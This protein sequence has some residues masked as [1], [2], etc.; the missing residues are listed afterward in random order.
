MTESTPQYEK[1]RLYSIIVIDFKRD[2]EQPRKYFDPEAL[3][4][5]AESIRKHGILQPVL[6]RPD[7]QGWV[8][9]VAGER[10]IEAAKMAGLLMIPAI[11]VEGNPDEI[12]LVENLQRR[13]LNPIEE[14][15]ALD[16]IMKKHNY[17]QDGLISVV[18][19]SKARISELLSLNR[20]PEEIK[21]ECRQNPNITRNILIEIA[22]SKQERGM[23]T[24]YK[25]YKEKQLTKEQLKGQ[26]RTQRKTQAQALLTNLGNVRSRM[27]A[28]DWQTWTDTERQELMTA[29]S[30]LKQIFDN[31]AVNIQTLPP[32]EETPPVT[33]DESPVSVDAAPAPVEQT[34]P[35]EEGPTPE[36]EIPPLDEG[37]A[38]MEEE[39]TEPTEDEEPVGEEETTEVKGPILS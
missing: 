24:L 33:V 39:G 13:D 12:S 26:S 27:S 16:R 22:K 30:G 11:M 1:G 5:L 34:P 23:L 28:M 36:E 20:L 32:F 3:E 38:I 31:A 6:F 8:V 2:P 10:R 4:E 29:M 37:I 7:E 18:N 35:P 21:N 9:I 14:A 19:K 17:N 15:E 25:K